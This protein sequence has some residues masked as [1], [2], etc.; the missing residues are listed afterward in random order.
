MYLEA[1]PGHPDSKKPAGADT[2]IGGKENKLT[3]MCSEDGM[4]MHQKARIGDGE[5]NDEAQATW[6]L[7]ECPVCH[8]LVVEFKT[9]F[10]VA[11]SEDARIRGGMLT[12]MA[13]EKATARAL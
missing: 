9:V 10:I 8:Q 13:M 1:G 3:M 6:M 12:V 2:P 4:Q 11:D 7:M 5:F